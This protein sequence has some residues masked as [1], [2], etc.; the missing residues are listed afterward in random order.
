M[1]N[2]NN[3][4]AQ[5]ITIQSNKSHELIID[6]GFKLA[7]DRIPLG[8]KLFRHHI[9]FR[10][11]PVLLVGDID[12][13]NL[14]SNDICIH[15]RLIQDHPHSLTLIHRNTGSLPPNIH[16]DILPIHDLDST[17]T[18]INNKDNIGRLIHLQ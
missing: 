13:G 10:F 6:N 2:S 8:N 1:A 12:L 5:P 11:V 15:I 9:S 3:I 16:L 4:Y 7:L 14:R 17:H 18:G